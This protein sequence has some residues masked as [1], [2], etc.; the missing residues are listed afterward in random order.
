MTLAHP[1]EQSQYSEHDTLYTIEKTP[2]DMQSLSKS[3]QL[4]NPLVYI[5]RPAHMENT[6]EC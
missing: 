5:V 6:L 1:T 4:S 2:N 3:E